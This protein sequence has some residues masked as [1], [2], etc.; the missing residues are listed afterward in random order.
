ML[1]EISLMF[2][3]LSA[4]QLTNNGLR[5]WINDELTMNNLGQDALV[6]LRQYSSIGRDELMANVY[7]KGDI[8]WCANCKPITYT[9][10]VCIV[11]QVPLHAQ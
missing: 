5:F 2:P 9:I 3:Y 7:S 6:H 8:L 10:T 11:G 1:I 4:W